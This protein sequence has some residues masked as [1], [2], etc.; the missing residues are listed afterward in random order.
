MMA[1]TLSRFP[2]RSL[3]SREYR[4]AEAGEALR[5]METLAVVKALVRP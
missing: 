3:I 1:R 2:W 5:D 4:L